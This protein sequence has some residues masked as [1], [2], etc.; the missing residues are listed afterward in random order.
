MLVEDIWAG[1]STGFRPP[2][3]SQT[4]IGFFTAIHCNFSLINGS[5]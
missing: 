1:Y 3:F 4:E 2:R 5:F